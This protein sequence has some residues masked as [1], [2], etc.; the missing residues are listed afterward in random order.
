MNPF[1]I[2]LLNMSF[3]AGLLVP[4]VVLLR[5]VLKKAPKWTRCVLWAFVA[6]RLL[7]PVEIASPLSL[8]NAL[9]RQENGSVEYFYAAGGSEKPLVSFD[10]YRFDGA[11]APEDTVI[12]FTNGA[13]P[14]VRHEATR[15]LPP[16]VTAWAIGVGLML[17]YLLWSYARLR[18]RVTASAPLEDRVWICDG[19]DAPFILGLFRPRIYIPSTLTEP[20]LSYVLAHEQAHLARRDHWWKPLGFALLAVHWFNPLLWLAYFLLCRDIELACD[21]K[22]FRSMDPAARTD[23][24]QALLDLSRPRAIAACPL[25][26]GETGVK[27]RVKAALSYKKPAFWLI[28]AAIALCAV[29]AVSFLTNPSYSTVVLPEED[30]ILRQMMLDRGMSTE[31]LRTDVLY[32]RRGDAWCLMAVSDDS[33]MVVRR[34]G[35]KFMESVEQSSDPNPYRGYMDVPKFCF[36]PLVHMIR[37][38]D[39]RPECEADEN[40]FYDL[41]FE[42][43]A[44]RIGYRARRVPYPQA[45]SGPILRV[46]SGAQWVSTFENFSWSEQWNEDGTGLSADGLDI[47]DRIR[48]NAD[49]IPVLT[50]GG[51]L[52]MLCW[53]NAELPESSFLAFDYETLEQLIPFDGYDG[54]WI[55]AL[56]RRGPGKYWC[57]Q[58]VHLRGAYVQGAKHYNMSG[59]DCVFCLEIPEGSSF[60]PAGPLLTVS[61][62]EQHVNA[63]TAVRYSET[64]E[65]PVVYFDDKSK[66]LMPLDSVIREKINRIPELTYVGD[67]TAAPRSDVVIIEKELQVFDEALQ[68]VIRRS[69]GAGIEA[70]RKLEPGVYFCAI[71]VKWNTTPVPV[72]LDCLVRLVVPGT[73]QHI[74]PLFTVHSGGKSVDAYPVLRWSEEGGMS[75]DGE[76]LE[77]AIPEHASEIPTLNYVG[78]LFVTLRS[79]AALLPDE[80]QVYDEAM[81]PVIEQENGVGMN[82]IRTL[83]PGTYYCAVAVKTERADGTACYD[84]TFRLVIPDRFTAE[85]AIPSDIQSYLSELPAV[86]PETLAE[87]RIIV[88]DVSMQIYNKELWDVF[89][90]NVQIGAKADV[91]IAVYEDTQ[92]FVV[93]YLRY[94]GLNIQLIRDDSRRSFQGVYEYT[95]ETYQYAQILT[96][97]SLQM[98]VLSDV[99][100]DSY[101]QYYDSLQ[102]APEKA[103]LLVMAWMEGE[104][105][106][107]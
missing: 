86:G 91:A 52:E 27:A 58:E 53:D 100:Y 57:C 78:G 61:S 19:I 16:L 39:A 21:E 51:D 87:R 103:P 8:F 20:R 33:F 55:N 99:R 9:G 13:P 89:F 22:V 73:E 105:G 98:V 12:S 44:G 18:R 60:E 96:R 34:R 59:Y 23:Y 5:L 45:T 69:D 68:P 79:D 3:A 83:E 42:K 43:P 104:K 75:A 63:L 36:G 50:W 88:N 92:H 40:R 76:P 28:L 71:P 66:T 81:Q 14:L 48:E 74:G 67:F 31:N 47:R 6:L 4:V 37:G 94:D 30:Q 70:V 10:T 26:F 80:L 93:Y 85:E 56:Q 32:N 64:N 101:E 54:N 41:R 102:H 65:D 77:T 17:L 46:R 11:A 38:G 107:E 2:K 72:F 97:D 62:G 82:G 24:S 35:Y 90:A 7:L 25:A 29:A 49:V 84:C 1:F 15:Y 106:R 95:A